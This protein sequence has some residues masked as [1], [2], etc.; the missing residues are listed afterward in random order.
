MKLIILDRDGVINYD[1]D[2]Y[3][4]SV[5]EFMPIP[6]SLEAIAR[7]NKAGYHV[8]V[9]TNQSGIA[10]GYYDEATLQQMHDK[11]RELLAGQGGRVDGIVYCPHGPDDHCDCRKPLPGLLERIAHLSDHPLENVPVVGDSLRDI[12]SARA[13]GATPYLVRTGKGEQTLAR[14]EGVEGVPVYADLARFVDDFLARE[15]G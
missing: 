6:G 2:D 3:I 5:D 9:A 4:K 14:G 13:V 7:L 11:L 1:S 12:E 8:Y 15:E 10:R